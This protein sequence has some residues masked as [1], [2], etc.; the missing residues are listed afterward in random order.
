M[1]N[2]ENE[3][4]DHKAGAVVDSQTSKDSLGTENAETAKKLTLD[5]QVEKKSDCIR[6]VIVTIPVED[7]DRYFQRQF[8]DLM[9]RAEVP[10]FRPGK[11]P[12]K[13]IESKFRKT[14]AE[15]VKGSLLM[16]SLTQISEDDLFSAIGEPDFDFDAVE[17]D[18]SKAL[19]FEFNIEVRPEF[20][21]PKWKGLKLV[22]PEH[23]YSAEEVDVYAKQILHRSSDWLPV[24]GPVAIE[25]SVTVSVVTLV[26][27]EQVNQIEEMEIEAKPI[28]SFRDCELSGF[29][30]LI[31]GKEVGE[32]FE[33]SVDI[34]ENADN[35]PCRGKKATAKFEVVDIKRPEVA[36][37]SNENL[38][39]FGEQ[40]TDLGDVRDAIKTEL[41]NQLEYAQNQKIRAQISDLLTESANWEL[42]PELLQRQ[43]L[44]ELE[45]AVLE[46]RR[47]NLSESAIAAYENDLRRNSIERTKTALKE[48]FI[49][50][51]IA[52]E[53]K[54]EDE[55]KDYE[56]EIALIANSMRDTPRRVRARLERN[57]QM[58]TLRN[59]IIE[60][61]V[62][63]KI[64]EL[65]TFEAIPFDV[66]KHDTFAAS[67]SLAG[68]VNAN[69]PEAKSDYVA[70][71][72]ASGTGDHVAPRA[73]R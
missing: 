65:A 31:V 24:E 51:K 52:E 58:D 44:R 72:N 21:L 54:I 62:I 26:D 7:V 39:Y 6:H 40:F 25:D 33:V 64:K 4:L 67:R 68:R 46:M 47:N 3:T 36:E 23:D 43:S 59:Q 63:Q 11:A 71:T 60:R 19:Q 22:R 42:P 69:I 17:V 27:G 34:S 8:D 35:I 48:H 45:R 30:D 12:R 57:G 2:S 56:E 15:Q 38:H 53:E 5:V 1:A 13:L 70:P 32:S 28:L 29:G 49:L 16:D 61:K 73:G 37:L 50:E 18:P 41:Q 20:D 10:G 14:V 55:A 66:P 9:P